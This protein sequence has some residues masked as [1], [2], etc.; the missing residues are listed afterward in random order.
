MRPRFVLLNEKPQIIEPELKDIPGY[1]MSL[2]NGTED[3]F[4]K[5]VDALCGFK[6]NPEVANLAKYTKELLDKEYVQLTLGDVPS[7]TMAVLGKGNMI[8]GLIIAPYNWVEMCNDN[9]P[10]QLGA[11]IFCASQAADFYNGRL[12]EEIKKRGEAYE[13]EY[14]KG[15]RNMPGLELTDYQRYVVNNFPDG[16]PPEMVAPLKPIKTMEQMN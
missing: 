11:V 9:P 16:I 8:A 13:A 6:H 15:I 3:C 5:G 2:W 4:M 1:I 10:C 14:L 12:S 7:L